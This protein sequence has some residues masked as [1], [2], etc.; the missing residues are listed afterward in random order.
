[1]K[2][3]T[4]ISVRIVGVP[5]K[6]DAGFVLNFSPENGDGMFLQNIG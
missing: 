6:I 2:N 1:V 4:E 5:A 3:Y